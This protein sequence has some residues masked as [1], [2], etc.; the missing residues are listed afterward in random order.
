LLEPRLKES[1]SEAP[2]F[3]EAGAGGIALVRTVT[4]TNNR[5]LPRGKLQI[6]EHSSQFFRMGDRRLVTRRQRKGRREL[7][8]AQERAVETLAPRRTSSELVPILRRIYL[9]LPSDGDISADQVSHVAESQSMALHGLPFAV[10]HL[11][12]QN[13]EMPDRFQDPD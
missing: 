3:D 6:E 2:P 5:P 11:V 7:A 4:P 9:D 13:R 1:R 8:A 12:P 10:V